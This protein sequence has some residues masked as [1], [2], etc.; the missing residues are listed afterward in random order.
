MRQFH[1]ILQ[2]LLRG[3]G[4]NGVKLLSLTLG[5]TVGVLLFSQIAYELHYDT[6]YK[7]HEKLAMFGTRLIKKDGQKTGWEYDTYRPAA[8]TLMESLPEEVE[9]ATPFLMFMQPDLYK[10]DKK[11]DDVQTLTGDT[12]Y[13]R[14]MG[15]ELLQG[16]PHYLAQKG[17]VFISQSKA[18][19]WFGG[20]NPIGKT[21]NMDKSRELTVR[22]I[23]EDIPGNVLFR[24]NVIIS[25][26]TIE[27]NYGQ[28]T[29]SSNDI[30]MVYVRL[31]EADDLERINA[32]MTDILGRYTAVKDR[33]DGSTLEGKLLPAT[34]FYLSHQPNVQRLVILFILGISI[35][36]VSGMNYVLAAIST[37]GRRAKIV[38]VHKCCGAETG[39]IF[40]M[41]LTET[42]LLLMLSLLGCAGLLYLLSEPIEDLTGIYR[43]SELF[44]WQ[45]LW[46]PLTTVLVLFL[47][48]GV[49]P[50]RLFAR[51]PVTQVFRRY[52]DDKRSWKRSLLF[53]QFVGV[54]FILGLL[55]TSAWQ[56]HSLMTQDV[57]FR[58]E[59]LAVGHAG[60][61]F[62]QYGTEFAEGARRVADDLRRQPFVEEVGVSE[63]SLLT[64]YS[65]KP[66]RVPDSEA[67]CQLHYQYVAKGFPQAVGMELV[68]GRWPEHEGEALV[69]ENLVKNMHWGKQV[70]GRELEGLPALR[71][72][73]SQGD[74]R[75][76]GIIRDVRN[77]GFFNSKTNV[78]FILCPY[79]AA[80][81]HVR[82]K[83]P[84]SDNLMRL[85]QFVK[86]TYPQL[87]LSFLSYE[88]VRLEQN[89]SVS[90]F[91]NIVS[92]TS[93]C[94]FFIVLMGLIGYVN[95]E[96]QRRS[97]EIAI[98]KVNGAEAAD[99]LRLLAKDILKVAIGAVL[100]GI[101]GAYYV[102]GLWMEQFPDSTLLSPVWYGVLL[103]AL[104]LLI[105][106]TVVA[107]AWK[108][109]NENPVL[110]LKAE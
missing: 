107:K 26:P 49:L 101:G 45:T 67:F 27:E 14:T 39:H 16:D 72:H 42:G 44:T 81:F 32:R 3:K 88:E 76:V 91:R 110:S 103:I 61:G 78:A 96:T 25:L 71:G 100:L 31:R 52:T 79:I 85:N 10:D 46:V 69:T 7:E 97:K 50:G 109:A 94:I 80:T 11:L 98:R 66:I 87:G 104:L 63:Q 73:N 23:Y 18:R 90:R 75:V 38:G 53:V 41:F 105:V 92:V 35:F 57:G 12:L 20:E 108:I 51:I 4:S 106:S 19:E 48:A 33:W 82:L 29:W 95:N 36:F 5:L 13:F 15:I 54:A 2:T 55:L 93:L 40:G 64:H 102:S 6:F 47:L 37:L 60:A 43:L 83:A 56:F 28:G 17:S 68:E 99:I 86:D 21:L 8:A 59:R 77:M 70:I 84:G 58:T 1:Y 24:H 30:Y 74:A 62:G 34:D 65:S 9:C 89:E 22:G